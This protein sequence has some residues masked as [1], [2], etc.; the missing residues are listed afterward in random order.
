MHRVQVEQKVGGI[1]E[2]PQLAR[3]AQLGGIARAQERLVA[4]DAVVVLVD[5]ARTVRIAE[6][7]ARESGDVGERQD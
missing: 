7:E 4:P 2:R 5:V 1:D 3:A 6:I